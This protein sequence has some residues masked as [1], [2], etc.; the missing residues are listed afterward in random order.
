MALLALLLV[1]VTAHVIL[2]GAGLDRLLVQMPGW[3]RVGPLV[4]AT[5]AR[6]TDLGNG[7]VLYPVLG[8]SGPIAT[9]AAFA[10]ALA[11]H[12]PRAVTV[13]LLAAS[14]LCVLHSIATTQAAPAMLR[15]GRTEDD[16][17]QITPLMNRFARVSVVRAILQA[18]TTVALLWALV[19]GW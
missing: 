15:I 19:A 3:Y 17:A 2:G 14:V 6:A 5:Y 7:R 1:A 10:L 16:E 18:L 9:W 4:F 12:A 11:M 13:P 8:I